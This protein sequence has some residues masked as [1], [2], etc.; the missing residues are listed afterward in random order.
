MIAEEEEG[1]VSKLSEAESMRVDAWW[2]LTCTFNDFTVQQF[3][4]LFFIVSLVS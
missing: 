1:L 3:N 2:L 4:S